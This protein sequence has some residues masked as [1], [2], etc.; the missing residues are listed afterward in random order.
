M[1]LKTGS[2]TF[3][4]TELFELNFG[5]LSFFTI[6]EKKLF[7]VSAVSDSDVSIF[8]FSVRFIFSLD[9]DL[10]ESKGF[11]VFQNFLLSIKIFLIQ[12]LVTFF[13]SFFQERLIYSFVLH[14]AC[15]F[16]LFSFVK[17]CPSVSTFSLFLLRFPLL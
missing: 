7:K 5:I 15:R 11:T 3:S 17:S 1:A 12:I 14:K 2:L 6:S 10:S 9:T 13:F 8:S 16:R 4:V